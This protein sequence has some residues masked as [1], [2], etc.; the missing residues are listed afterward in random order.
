[1]EVRFTPQMY[2][3]HYTK[4]KNIT[5]ADIDVA[6]VVVLSWSEGVI[7]ALSERVGAESVPNWPWHRRYPFYTGSILGKRVSFAQVGVGAPATI[8]GME[9]MIA[10]GARIF[11]GL[12]W[13][14]SLQPHIPIGSILIP[15]RCISQEGTS[16]HYVKDSAA[17]VPDATLHKLLANGVQAMGKEA[18]CGLQWS[19]D[20]PY[21]EFCETIDAFRAQGVLGVDMETSAMYALGTYHRVKVCNML[22]ISDCVWQTW[23]PAAR[24][25]ELRSATEKAGDIV[26]HVLQNSEIYSSL[27]S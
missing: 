11:I 19:T 4:V 2:L 26:L 24:T 9:E 23:E 17:M 12:G 8:T 14:G 13:A 25:P 7:K 27:L 1:M 3:D 6:P 22:V 21:R 10:C 5:L 18:H 15:E 16:Q 20:A